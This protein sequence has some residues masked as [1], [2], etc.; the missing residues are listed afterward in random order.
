MHGTYQK[1][2]GDTTYVT[3]ASKH[4]TQEC[5]VRPLVPDKGHQ[6][7]VHSKQSQQNVTHGNV[8]DEEDADSVQSNG[9]VTECGDQDDGVTC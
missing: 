5:A 4:A 1:D 7:W 9:S 8:A 3:Q 2:T 6:V